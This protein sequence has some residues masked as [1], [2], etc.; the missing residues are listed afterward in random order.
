MSAETRAALAS[1]EGRDKV[2]TEL[3]V[4]LAEV[5]AQFEAH[6]QLA[7]LV[8]VRELW[9]IGNALL[10]PTLKIRRSQIEERYHNQIEGWGGSRCKVVFE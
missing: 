5:N 8:V 6:E 7:C 1:A 9:T 2:A 4:F 10:T 3:E